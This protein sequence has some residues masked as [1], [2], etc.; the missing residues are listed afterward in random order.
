MPTHDESGPQKRVGKT[1]V[2]RKGGQA[3]FLLNRQWEDEEDRRRRT[4]DEKSSLSPFLF[5]FFVLPFSGPDG[6]RPEEISWMTRSRGGAHRSIRFVYVRSNA[7]HDD[8]VSRKINPAAQQ[9]PLY[10][11]HSFVE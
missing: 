5:P 4:W 9:I 10:S 11:L 7:E 2:G 1:W 8:E 3:T 6:R